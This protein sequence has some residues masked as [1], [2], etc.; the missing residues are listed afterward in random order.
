MEEGAGSLVIV[1]LIVWIVLMKDDVPLQVEDEAPVSC[2]EGPCIPEVL[3][4]Y[5]QDLQ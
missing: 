2:T 4:A 1:F 5:V 3:P